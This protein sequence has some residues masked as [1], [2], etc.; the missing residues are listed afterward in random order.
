[1]KPDYRIFVGD[2]LTG[3]DALDQA[4]RFNQYVGV[5]GGILTKADADARGGAAISFMYATGKPIL[6]LGVG[7]GYDDLIPF[8]INWFLDKIVGES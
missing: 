5:D 7:Q 4:V 6:Y 3:N 2:A 1:V 8:D